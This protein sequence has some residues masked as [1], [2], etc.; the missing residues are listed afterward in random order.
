MRRAALTRYL[1]T[2]M[3]HVLAL[4]KAA[5]EGGERDFRF[6]IIKPIAVLPNPRDEWKQSLSRLWCRLRDRPDVL[7]LMLGGNLHN[8]FGL[9]NHPVPFHMDP[10]QSQGQFIPRN[11]MRAGM[12]QPHTA[13]FALSD[14]IVAAFPNARRLVVCAPPP[15]PD[16]AHI[17]R[18]AGSFR[19]NLSQG[20]APDAHRLALYNLQ[21][22][23]FRDYAKR[24]NAGFVTPPPETLTQ[25]GMLAMPFAFNDPTHANSAYGA[26]MLARIRAAAKEML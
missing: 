2:G 1:V 7:C 23:V 21:I 4:R 19:P 9:L 10:T 25:S 20:I 22:D 6:E 24:I 11:M 13:Q 8:V 26:L 16:P 18:Y 12:E 14:K 15:L 3:S 5:Q 17:R